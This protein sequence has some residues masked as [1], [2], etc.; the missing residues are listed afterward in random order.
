MQNFRRIPRKSVLN[1]NLFFY[2][3]IINVNIY[4]TLHNV[5]FIFNILQMNREYTNFLEQGKNIY[6]TFMDFTV[7]KFY[8]Q[9]KKRTR[10]ESLSIM[11]LYCKIPRE[12]MRTSRKRDRIKV[13]YEQFVNLRRQARGFGAR[14]N[15]KYA[16]SSFRTAVRAGE[17]GGAMYIPADALSAIRYK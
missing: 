10:A 13:R 12:I 2:V 6:I 17:V 4:I 1:V 5:F 8:A 14:P 9:N 15:I 3:N 11:Q 16:I 7:S